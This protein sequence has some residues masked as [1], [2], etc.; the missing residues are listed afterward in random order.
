VCLI[1]GREHKMVKTAVITIQ[2]VPEAEGLE[3]ANLHKQ[4]MKTLQCDWMFEVLNVEIT[5]NKQ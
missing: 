5:R 3:N 1:G 2:L 4:I